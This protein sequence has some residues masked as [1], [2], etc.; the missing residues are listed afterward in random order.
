MTEARGDI[1]MD[2]T[3]KNPFLAVKCD[4]CEFMAK[5]DRGLKTQKIESLKVVNG[6]ISFVKKKMI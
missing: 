5:S 3:F 6:V 4:L 2:Q 1:S